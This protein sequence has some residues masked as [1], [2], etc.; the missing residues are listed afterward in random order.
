MGLFLSTRLARAWVLCALLFGCLSLCACA[1]RDE[2]TLTDAC[3]KAGHSSQLGDQASLTSH[4]RCSAEVARKYLDPDDFRLLVS[5]A[6]IYN[7]NVSDGVKLRRLI[8]GMLASGLTPAK[9]S[10]A[11]LDLL[12]LAHKAADECS[13]VNGNV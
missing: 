9:A 7:E 6:A 3:V 2:A 12:S 5:V 13:S 1:G 8:D 4:C 11:A 10:V